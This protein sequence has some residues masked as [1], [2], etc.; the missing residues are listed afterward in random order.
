VANAL[1]AAFGTWLVD[2]HDFQWAV[3]TDASGTEYVVKHKVGETTAYPRA[4]VQKRIESKQPEFFHN[5]Y[6]IILDQL[7]RLGEQG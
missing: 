6:L 4:S 1:G 3:L 7:R 5:M 2:R